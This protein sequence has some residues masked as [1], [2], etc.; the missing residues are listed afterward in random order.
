MRGEMKNSWGSTNMVRAWCH[1]YIRPGDRITAGHNRPESLLFQHLFWTSS[2]PSLNSVKWQKGWPNASMMILLPILIKNLSL[3][4][5]QQLQ[6]K[7]QR[8]RLGCWTQHFTVKFPRCSHSVS[9]AFAI[10]TARL[11]FSNK[12]GKELKGLG[13]VEQSK[14]QS[15]NINTESEWCLCWP[16]K[17]KTP[18]LQVSTIYCNLMYWCCLPTPSLFTWK[19]LD[20]LHRNE[21]L[22]HGM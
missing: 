14:Q 2:T 11:F 17:H 10:P 21:R 13:I 12:E 4:I 3:D 22:S 9:E 20:L 1:R 15:R 18:A 6:C 19:T 7:G 5:T 8:Q 16:K